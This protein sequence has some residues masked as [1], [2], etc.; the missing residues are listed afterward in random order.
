[1]YLLP[2][3]IDLLIIIRSKHSTGLFEFR[4]NEL[5]IDDQVNPES[6]KIS[7]TGWKTV[8]LLL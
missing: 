7:P 3:V 4:K 2:V 8:L 1:M 6:L 5:T